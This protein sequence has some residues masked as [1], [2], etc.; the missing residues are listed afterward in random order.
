MRI[1]VAGG[2]GVLAR[3]VVPLLLAAGHDL[4]LTSRSAEK[5]RL[6]EGPGV[7]AAVL[8]ALD[9]D[10]TMATVASA[11]PDVVLHLMTDL[12]TGN[13]ASNAR[14]RST[15]TRNLVDAARAAGVDRI[16]AQSISWVYPPGTEP[17]TE[18]D[19]LDPDAAEPRRT[20]V[21]AVRALEDA[22]QEVGAGVVLRFGQLYGPGTWYSAE[23][24]FGEAARAGLLP[25]TE[26][27]TSFVHVD[28]AAAAVVAALG[29]TAG[30]RNVV[31]DEPASGT[32]WVPA[33]SAAVAGPT[34][35]V[36]QTGDLGRPVS[37]Q[38]ARESG[39]TPRWSSWRTGFARP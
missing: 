21:T 37:N 7:D 32:A 4:T 23:G 11:E 20:T 39:F 18:A 29:W 38:L 36:E 14:L 3:S 6:L 25:A 1:L 26:T 9:R 19:P 35:R 2:S 24:R 28:D 5:A 12:G 16:V 33:F 27:V 31:D 30:V 17:A 22:V 10:G 8:D 15:G 13:S 34:P